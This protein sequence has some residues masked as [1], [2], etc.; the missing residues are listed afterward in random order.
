MKHTFLTEFLTFEKD[1]SLARYSRDLKN[2]GALTRILS[3]LR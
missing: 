3:L 1:R 2:R